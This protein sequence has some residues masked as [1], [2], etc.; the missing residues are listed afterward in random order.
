M[1][2]LLDTWEASKERSEQIERRER[3]T[4]KIKRKR[5]WRGKERSGHKEIRIAGPKE[6]PKMLLSYQWSGSFPGSGEA[7]CDRAST[8]QED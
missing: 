2:M 1:R 6:G 7:G 4:S 5:K 3:K 8:A